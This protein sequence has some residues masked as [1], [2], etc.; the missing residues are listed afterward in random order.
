VYI[1]GWIVHTT[2][3]DIESFTIPA[4][5]SLRLWAYGKRDKEDLRLSSGS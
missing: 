5:T 1:G 3:G 2:D 4:G